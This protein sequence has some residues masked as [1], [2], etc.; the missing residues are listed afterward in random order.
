MIEKFIF[1]KYIYLT[2]NEFRRLAIDNFQKG[3]T[4]YVLLS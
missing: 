2:R 4:Y 1:E 3:F